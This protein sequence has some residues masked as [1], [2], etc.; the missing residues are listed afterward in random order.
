MTWIEF[1]T[2]S[3]RSAVEAEEAFRGGNATRAKLLYEQAA[4]AEQKAL[5]AVDSLKTRTRGITAVSAVALW[6]KAA[7]LDRAEQLA[8]SMLADPSLPD[9]ARADLRTLVQA[10]W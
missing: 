5:A 1:H 3:E 4:D 7:A 8:H 2:A 6:Y 10:I 9:F